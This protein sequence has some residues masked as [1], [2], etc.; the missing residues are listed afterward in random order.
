MSTGVSNRHLSRVAAPTSSCKDGTRASAPTLQGQR[1]IHQHKL[2]CSPNL[3]IQGWHNNLFFNIARTALH[4][5]TETSTPQTLLQPT[6]SPGKDGVTASVPTLESQTSSK[7]RAVLQPQL[8]PHKDGAT[9]VAA[10]CKDGA[11]EPNQ[12]N[13]FKTRLFVRDASVS[14]VHESISL[15]CNQQ[16]TDLQI[17]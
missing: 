8:H 1:C 10:R 9:A 11:T 16:K 3:T 14:F 7:L 5:A 12:R 2:C 15:S 6:T 4:E 13:G 17:K